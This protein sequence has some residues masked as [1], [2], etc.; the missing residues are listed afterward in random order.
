MPSAP[1]TTQL[2]RKEVF[3]R[4]REV[5]ARDS[6]QIRGSRGL[7]K[8]VAQDPSKPA[9]ETVREASPTSDAESTWNSVLAA[10]RLDLKP[11]GRALRECVDRDPLDV[12]QLAESRATLIE[13]RKILDR[14]RQA[15]HDLRSQQKTIL[16]SERRAP[17]RMLQVFASIHVGDT[18]KALGLLSRLLADVSINTISRHLLPHLPLALER[19]S[20]REDCSS[21]LAVMTP[22]FAHRRKLGWHSHAALRDIVGRLGASVGDPVAWLETQLSKTRVIPNVVKRQKFERGSA[23]LI[24]FGVIENA[25]P[26]TLCNLYD[27]IQRHGIVLSASSL[28]STASTLVSMGLR[29][30]AHS[31][32]STI[33]MT[34]KFDADTANTVL[35][36]LHDLGLH[37]AAARIL[38]SQPI[39]VDPKLLLDTLSYCVKHRQQNI[40]LAIL[41][42]NVPRVAE[43][44]S[45][46]APARKLLN[47]DEEVLKRLFTSYV[48]IGDLS[49][50]EVLLRNMEAR[51]MKLGT[52]LY[53]AL[54][55]AYTVG[56]DAVSAFRLL[57]RMQERSLTL[58]R[59]TYT[60]LMSMYV[61]QRNPTAVQRTFDQMQQKGIVP[62]Q[63]SYAILL[64]AYI[65]AGDWVKAASIWRSLPRAI[66]SDHNIANTLLK[67]MVI[68]SAPYQEVYRLFLSAYVEP[69]KADQRAWTI[70]IQ[71]ACDSG[72]LARA[73]ELYDDFKLL[74]RHS[75]P[76][77]RLDHYLSSILVVG[78]IRYGE[79]VAAKQ[80]HDEMQREGVI[81][82]SVIYAAIIDAA[83]QGL[84]PMPAFRAKELAH[85]LLRESD[86]LLCEPQHG[87]AQP[88]ENII[89]PLMRS[90]I[91]DRDTEEAE[92]LFE[93]AAEKGGQP[94]IALHSML[95]DAYRQA[96]EYDR[97]QHVWNAI[98]ASVVEEKAARSRLDGSDKTL[99]SDRRLCIP[100]SIYIDAMSSARR[101]ED[102][103]GVWADMRKH[104]FGFDAHNW[105]HFA[106][107]L[108]RTG[109]VLKAFDIVENVLIRRQEE[110]ESRSFIGIRPADS[111]SERSSEGPVSV[112]S[113]PIFEEQY[114]ESIQRPPNRR[115]E[116]RRDSVA[117]DALRRERLST[118]DS[119]AKSNNLDFDP[120]VFE[121]WRPADVVWRPA[122]LTVAVLERMYTDMEQGRSMVALVAPEEEEGELEGASGLDDEGLNQN[123]QRSSPVALLAMVNRKY[124]KTVSLIMLHRRKRRDMALVRKRAVGSDQ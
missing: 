5:S 45:G 108:V 105:N 22:L 23:E 99:A 8:P 25:S 44:L 10:L 58:D 47:L 114:L 12:I 88:V 33:D 27:Q 34:A 30:K 76:T 83:L 77:L 24:L 117:Y 57:N 79:I 124:A 6:T 19:L 49:Y 50:A 55:K 78:H 107:A 54:F 31:I 3:G 43:T 62:D 59:F 91:H 69:S 40:V 37:V 97:V 96:G 95:L 90:A 53:N 7:V 81:N 120:L 16:V 70:L 28:A 29:E 113:T 52:G 100:L 80:I 111:Q 60:T 123:I 73:R 46:Q 109:D 61:N 38:V 71:S 2:R 110:L 101:G 56:H 116:F 26:R 51:D 66:Q 65:E 68:L 63:I 93:L 4:E 18:A 67:G 9:L 122:Y 42:Q 85:R 1:L 75:Q 106:V 104:G 48:S 82:T 98:F 21:V 64:N 72:N 41:A 36:M 102:I 17:L 121:R 92:R 39:I 15:L 112:S 84:W 13:W 11:G 14:S 35:R 87:R 94:S 86:A 89:V 115:H 74:T 20:E 118:V 119:A 103:R 32:Y